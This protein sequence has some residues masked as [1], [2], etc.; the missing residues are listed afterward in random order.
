MASA[1]DSVQAAALGRHE[2]RR[3]YVHI[4]SLGFLVAAHPT[5]F[6]EMAQALALSGASRAL[7]QAVQ[8]WVTFSPPEVD[9]E[10]EQGAKTLHEKA[11][12]A[13]QT[14][15]QCIVQLDPLRFEAT[16]LLL[17]SSEEINAWCSETAYL[18]YATDEDAAAVMH[19]EAGN[20]PRLRS[21]IKR[22]PDFDPNLKIISGQSLFLFDRR[23]RTGR[24]TARLYKQQ[25]ARL[26]R[27]FRRTT[28]PAGTDDRRLANEIEQSISSSSQTFNGNSVAESC[29]RDGNLMVT[30]LQRSLPSTSA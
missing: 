30:M 9:P 23:I 12:H 16:E 28:I 22:S 10:L 14:A 15:F 13:L 18:S 17:G 5:F 27:D 3:F 24:G 4:R 19:A 20:L 25:S 8:D 6:D 29:L 21:E 1:N 26:L 7:D 2:S 11:A